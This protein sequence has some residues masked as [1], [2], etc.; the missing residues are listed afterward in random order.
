MLLLHSGQALKLCG[1]VAGYPTLLAH[2]TRALALTAQLRQC[3]EVDAAE[4]RAELDRCRDWLAGRASDQPENFYH[5]LLLV[6]AERAWAVGDSHAALAK[7]DE[8]AGEARRRQRPWHRAL[9]AERTARFCLAH[10]LPQAARRSLVE[11]RREYDAWG[12]NAKVA[13]LDAA[14]PFLIA[15][16]SHSSS[17][18][19]QPAQTA[20]MS[21]ATLDMLA[22]LRASQA[23][24]SET[25]LRQLQAAIV[26]Q[27]TALT[28]ATD[29]VVVVKDDET[30][31]WLVPGS[32][33][34][35]VATPVEQAAEAGHLPATAFRYAE[36]TRCPLLVEDATRDSRFARDAYVAGLHCCS[37]LVVPVL[38]QGVI[39]AMLVLVNRLS[40]GVFTAERLDT[41]M[42]IVGQLA[43]SLR[44]AMLYD[45]L[46][47][48]VAVR[49]SELATANQQLEKLSNTD[50]L[51]GL[52]N[53]YQFSQALGSAWEESLRQGQVLALL[54]IDVD[55]F[56]AFN[57][58]YGHP[59]GDRCLRLVAVTLAGRMR[60][61][62][63]LCRYGGE[64]FVAILRDVDDMVA[65]NIG[66]RICEAMAGAGHPHGG[67]EMGFVTVSVGVS[68]ILPGPDATAE[69]LIARADAAL[70]EAKQHGRNRACFLPADASST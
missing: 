3:P 10:H 43:V 47:A 54:M 70:Y 11:A 19:G 52:A 17:V 8:A 69:D 22:I 18:T 56:K 68:T 28:G 57:D 48:R 2:L 13:A 14:H 25:N 53:R 65:W 41:V 4:L 6:D 9:I 36:R 15:D 29:I 30:G 39:Q 66:Q 44:N 12:A 40:G 20:M 5:L 67:S 16:R 62:D 49:T 26:E 21:D 64:E 33:R 58:R 45:S 31:R 46:E 60:D 55:H 23:L 7:Y 63:L 27:L 50:A 38:H 42:L 35:D 37:L 51:T 61:G 1:F 24:S 32:G 34:D 59:E